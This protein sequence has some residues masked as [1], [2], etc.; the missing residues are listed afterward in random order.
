MH[1]YKVNEKNVSGHEI[2]PNTVAKYKYKYNLFTV[3]YTGSGRPVR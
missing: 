2:A 3:K 1:T